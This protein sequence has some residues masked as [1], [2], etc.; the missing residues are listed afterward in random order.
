VAGVE[1]LLSSNFSLSVQSY[2]K[3]YP[4]IVVYNRDKLYPTDPDFVS[5]T[6]RAYGGEVLTRF[7]SA[8]FDAYL[9]YSL[10]WTRVTNGGVTYPPRYDRRHT[11]NLLGVVHPLRDVD[12]AVRWEFGTGYPFTQSAGYY[13]RLLFEGIGSELSIGEAGKAYS[14]LGNKN[15]A[16]LPAYYRVDASVTHHFLLSPFRGSVGASVANLTDRKNILSYDRKTGRRINMLD[17]FPSA[18]LKVEF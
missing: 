5:G 9:S 12:V 6:G 11:I 1:G 17:F 13:D 8:G 15:A 3:N 2:L 10:A 18:T 4:S 14:V 16:R 7:R